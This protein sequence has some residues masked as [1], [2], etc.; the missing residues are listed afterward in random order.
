M[1][2][3]RKIL[4]FLLICCAWHVQA[5]SVYEVGDKQADFMIKAHQVLSRDKVN[6]FEIE[7]SYKAM[8][9]WSLSGKNQRP[10]MEAGSN[11][12]KFDLI[13]SHYS[14]HVF[15]LS[16]AQS[17][18]LQHANVYIQ[19]Q[20][21]SPKALTLSTYQANV[22]A[23]EL[24]IEPNTQATVWVNISAESRFSL[25]LQ[26]LSSQPFLSFI[27]KTQFE[28][29]V[30][31][32]GVVA[33]ALM[34]LFL[35]SASGSTKVLVLSAYFMTR[36][37]LLSVIL[38]VNLLWFLPHLKELLAIQ[39]PILTAASIIFLVWF[40]SKLFTLKANYSKQFTYLKRICWILLI[41]MPLSL[42]LSLS[43]NLL[44][45]FILSISSSLLLMALGI[46]LIKQKQRLARVFTA[47]MFIQLVLSV[48]NMWWNGNGKDLDFYAQNLNLY[49]I[50]FWLNGFF[51]IFLLSREHYYQVL[52]R[53]V[54]QRQALESAT[55]SKKAQEALL[56]LQEESQEQLEIRVQERTLE[57]NIALQE[58]EEANK[59]LA[60]KNTRDE[61]TGLYNRRH[62]DQKI[63]AEYRRSRR[64]LTPLSLVIID[65]DHF[66]KVNDTL[67][68]LAGDQCIA[69]VAQKIKESIGR[70]SDTACRYGGEEF[71]LILP[72]T[73][74]NGALVLAETL[75][76]NIEENP[77]IFQEDE[78]QL[79]ISAGVS[80]YQQQS[81]ATTDMLFSTADKA[82]YV[83]KENGR[84]QVRSLPIT[85][86]NP[87]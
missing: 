57:L 38:G 80:T 84:N 29:G 53:D 70:G 30:A 23:A 59:E 69:F 7:S 28:H 13:N 60:E 79:K 86:E 27:K 66:K 21:K 77:L 62:Y 72:E 83:A 5:S 22:S 74:T 50:S 63:L 48:I 85:Q 54:M 12:I 78:I 68:H 33:L 61:L 18:K 36:A 76:K 17:V 67:G 26:V 35:Y 14:N 82:L 75:R 55:A 1:S 49:A 64:N 24:T 15:Y 52:D 3:L 71:C 58:L 42:K 65:I 56:D 37:A 10:V 44:I 31:I 16:V 81:D 8:S 43:A 2:L 73:D 6:D 45:T 25:K 46:Y 32:G 20:D 9:D 34:M 41:Y 11:W 87:S 47:L 51:M 4:G 40:T 39:I 19:Y